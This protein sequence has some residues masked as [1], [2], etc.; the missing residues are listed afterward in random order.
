MK[1]SKK[2]L[3]AVT[4]IIA[5]FTTDLAFADEKENVVEVSGSK[6]EKVPNSS[7]FTLVRNSKFQLCHEIKQILNE[8]END[9]FFAKRE[10]GEW[11]KYEIAKDQFTIPKRYQ[12]FQTPKWEDISVEEAY[13][14][15]SP[16]GKWRDRIEK[17]TKD[18]TKK[19]VI[20]KTQFDLAHQGKKEDILRM[21]TDNGEFWSCYVRDTKTNRTELD[22]NNYIASSYNNSSNKCHLFYYKGR[23]YAGRHP[24]LINTA[25]YEPFITGNGEFGMESVCEF[26]TK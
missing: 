4:V 12:N 15:I 6:V 5:I 8:P 20:Q 7:K 13:L 21:T 26:E 14:Y 9:D 18:K 2:I 17:I 10:P 23:A 24:D 3:Q 19:L 1:S 22:K 25:I 16:S 11:R